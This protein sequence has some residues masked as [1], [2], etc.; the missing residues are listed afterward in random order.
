MLENELI[1]HY[2]PARNGVVWRDKYFLPL[3]TVIW[4]WGVV[5]LR[6]RIMHVREHDFQSGQVPNG[7]GRPQANQPEDQ[8]APSSCKIAV[9]YIR[10]AIACAANYLLNMTISRLKLS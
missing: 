10:K 2:F 4:V 7:P 6:M 9:R 3:A 8:D 1:A 5:F